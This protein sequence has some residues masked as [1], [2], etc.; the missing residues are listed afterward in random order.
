MRFTLGQPVTFEGKA[1]LIQSRTTLA[2]G[3]P[4]MVLQEEKDQFVISASAFLA[5]ISTNLE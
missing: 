3:E 4:A 2:S 1:Y 5:G